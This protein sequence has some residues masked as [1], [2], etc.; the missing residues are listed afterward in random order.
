MRMRLRELYEAMSPDERHSLAEK[1]GTSHAYLWQMATRWNG[2]RASMGM[3]VK[4]NAA[5]PRLT[6][7]DLA[8]EFTEPA[9]A[10]AKA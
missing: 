7:A 6:I 10:E 8:S 4:L 3:I 5:D 1:T 9:P 2:R